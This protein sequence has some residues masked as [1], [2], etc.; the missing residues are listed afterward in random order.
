MRALEAADWRPQ[1]MAHKERILGLVH[2]SIDV[3]PKHPIF[4]FLFQYY[5]FPPGLLLKWS[6]GIYASCNGVST[7]REPLLWTGKGWEWD[8]ALAG[9]GHMAPKQCVAS[10]RRA[11]RSAAEIMRVCQTRAP[12][13]NCFGLHEWAMLY[14]PSA[15][16]AA[17]RRHQQL[18]LRLS[19]SELNA[20]VEEQQIGCTHFDAFRFFTPEATPLNTVRDVTRDRQPAN[21][22]PGCVHSSMDL[23]RYSLQLWPWIPAE[24]LADTLELAI[25]ARVL[26]MRASPYDLSEY[27]CADGQGQGFDLSPVPIERASG[28]RTYQLIQADLARR[29]APLRTRLLREYEAVI[30]VWDQ[31]E[32]QAGP[33]P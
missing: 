20:V 2:G 11:A 23:F 32:A 13:L 8:P 4:N 3:D 17:P 33:E 12:H 22:Q 19:Q 9:S 7:A 10:R 1:A 6:P 25:A 31:E 30:A 28:R 24:L 18:P 21:E 16:Q 5:S 15:A 26:D 27:H 14:Q 29:A